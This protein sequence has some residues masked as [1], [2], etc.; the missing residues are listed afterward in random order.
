MS[1]PTPCTSTG[2][3][4]V[5]RCHLLRKELP[6]LQAA[7]LH[8]SNPPISVEEGGC[9]LLSHELLV[10][11]C[12]LL[13]PR[14]Q[15]GCNLFVILKIPRNYLWQAS[16]NHN[17]RC[18]SGRVS[19]AAWQRQHR[20]TRGEDLCC[21]SMRVIFRGVKKQISDSLSL[22]SF[23]LREQVGK[24]EEVFELLCKILEVPLSWQSLWPPQHPHQ[25]LSLVAMVGAI[26]NVHPGFE[27]LRLD[28]ERPVK[29][30]SD[31]CS[32]RQPESRPHPRP[33]R[34]SHDLLLARAL[35]LEC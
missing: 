32:V 5:Q 22:D 3:H 18:D 15:L 11:S 24:D 13:R 35:S 20:N 26:E 16:S 29:I 8:L 7:R 1:C 14:D 33:L 4:S 9:L 6:C 12:H 30:G 2:C 27:N 23:L 25:N 28:L 19:L 21:C 31:E 34:C 10:Q 17:A